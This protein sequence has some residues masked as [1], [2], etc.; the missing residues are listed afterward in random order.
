MQGTGMRRRP[1]GWLLTMLPIR[2]GRGAG[3]VTRRTMPQMHRIARV[4]ARPARRL[5]AIASE[6]ASGM[7]VR[8]P[9]DCG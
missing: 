1:L 2:R 3:P 9:A 7:R 5:P 6:F 4:A 8:C